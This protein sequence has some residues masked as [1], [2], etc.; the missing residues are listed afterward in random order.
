MKNWSFLRGGG[1]KG[2]HARY[3]VTLIVG[4]VMILSLATA[5]YILTPRTYSSGF[6]LIL[7]GAGASSSVSIETLGQTSTNAASAYGSQSLSP[8]ENYK[9]LLQSYRLRGQVA[10]QF[11]LPLADVP[12]P[13]IRLANQTQLIYVSLTAHSP[14]AAKDFADAWLSVFDSEISA[15]RIEEQVIRENACRSTLLSFEEA[16]EQ[17]RARIIA[18]QT[19]H[20]LISVEQFQ[21]L[22]QRSETMKLQAR[23]AETRADVAAREIGRLSA[24]LGVSPDRAA[25][26]MMLQSDPIFQSLYG[27]LSDAENRR[28]ELANMYGT[29]HP[30][31][32]VATEEKAGL[33]AALDERGQELIGFE[34]F[35]SIEVG[36]YA[37]NTERAR[38][39][40]GLVQAATSYAGARQELEALQ[41]RQAET[42]ARVE[43]LAE[44]ATELDAL[45]RDH[46]VAETVFASALARIDTNRTD[47][48]A[49]YPLTQTVEHPELPDAPVTPSRQLVAIGTIGTIFLY[50]MGLILLWIRLPIIR[51]LLKTV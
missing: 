12:A 38:L 4:V 10:K 24:M 15:L 34:R 8:T 3:A 36:Q 14:Q 33:Q 43:L 6:T 32:R 39:I 25:K 5:V 2:R 41:F 45:L 31:L 22:V 42:T 47:M 27:S 44:P 49:S 29:N 23:D 37:A 18:F 13:R 1:Q 48:F 35:K 28:A 11:D 19:E 40:S 16:V 21:N 7:P 26:V 50:S 30:E 51:L 9:K 46:Q 17:S 20:G